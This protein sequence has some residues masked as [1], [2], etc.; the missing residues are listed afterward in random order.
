[1]VTTS[2]SSEARM[3][4]TDPASPLGWHSYTPSAMP[5]Y[6]YRCEN[7]H[8]V[9][10][11]AAHDRR[12]AARPA[13]LRRAGRSACSTRSP[14]TSRAR[15]STTP[16]T[17]RSARDRELEKSAKDGADKHDAKMA[18]AEEGRR[19][20][21]AKAVRR[22]AEG[23]R[24]AGREEGLAAPGSAATSRALLARST[25]QAGAAVWQRH[26]CRSGFRTRVG[27]VARRSPAPP[28]RPEQRRAAHVGL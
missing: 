1:M 22:E 18:E 4:A 26:R 9:R 25:T 10:G 5:I 14:C 3:V 7:G 2:A 23:R 19:Q 12:P 16:T 15:A 20:E 28:N 11:H 17:A 21:V 6:E 24:Q 13:R 8:H 27:G